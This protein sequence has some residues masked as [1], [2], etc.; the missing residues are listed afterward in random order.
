MMRMTTL[1]QD[2][3]RSPVSRYRNS[4]LEIGLGQ[5]SF[6]SPAPGWAEAQPTPTAKPIQAV[7][8]PTQRELRLSS[9][10]PE[11]LLSTPRP[12]DHHRI[13][14]SLEEVGDRPRL[15]ATGGAASNVSVKITDSP[16]LVTERPDISYIRRTPVPLSSTNRDTDAL[17]V[18]QQAAGGPLDLAADNSSVAQRVARGTGDLPRSSRTEQ[19]SGE[20]SGNSHPSYSVH[21]VTETGRSTLDA[22]LGALQVALVEHEQERVGRSDSGADWGI[23]AVSLHK[24]KDK[25]KSTRKKGAAKRASSRRTRERQP[26]S[27]RRHAGKRKKEKNGAIDA[28]STQMGRTLVLD[29]VRPSTTAS[30]Y[31]NISTARFVV[32]LVRRNIAA[33]SHVP[34]MRLREISALGFLVSKR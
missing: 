3:L 29:R 8:D 1:G 5:D 30:S 34:V 13:L 24:K 17:P 12:E 16:N 22:D 25:T 19:K 20:G 32:G 14:T 15:K 2:P 26:S 18:A 23:N 33:L 4:T 10:A 27:R 9:R 6:Q 7:H 21:A 28:R 11:P 31:V